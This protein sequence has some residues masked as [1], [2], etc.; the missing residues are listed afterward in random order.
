MF[1]KINHFFL[2]GVILASTLASTLFFTND[3]NAAPPGVYV[4]PKVKADATASALRTTLALCFTWKDVNHLKGNGDTIS[5]SDIAKGE[6]FN[7]SNSSLKARTGFI[8]DSDDGTVQCR[9]LFEDRNVAGAFGYGTNIELACGIGLTRENGSNCVNGTGDFKDSIG[10][11]ESKIYA[12]L[13]KKRTNATGGHGYNQIQDY[14]LAAE[15]YRIA[16]KAKAVVEV[17]KATADQK[18]NDDYHQV[19]VVNSKGEIVEVLYKRDNNDK[20]AWKNSTAGGNFD[21]SEQKC[22]GLQAVMNS[23]AKEYSAYVQNHQEDVKDRTSDQG[24]KDEDEEGAGTSCKVEAVG[25]VICP[26]MRF[27]SQVTDQAYNILSFFLTVPALSTD[28]SQGLYQAWSVMRNF[29]NVAF[30]IAFMVIIYSQITGTG[31]NNYGIKKMLPKL[32]IAAILVNISYWICAIAVDASNIVGSSLKGL[33]DSIAG[34]LYTAEESAVQSG[35]GGRWDLLTVGL[36]GGTAAGIAIYVGLSALLPMLIMALFAVVTVVLI[37][38]LRQALIVILVFLSPLAFVAFLLP[39]T[40]SLFNKWKNLFQLLL[41]M[42]PII[43][44]LFGACKLASTVIMESNP[45]FILQVLAAGVTVIP[46]FIT[47]FII[48]STSGFLNRWTG[49]VNNPNKGPFDRMRKRAEAYRDYRNDV[50]RGNRLGRASKLMSAS[51]GKLGDSYSKRRRALGYLASAGETSAVNKAKKRDFAKAVSSDSS[52][53]YL[54]KRALDQ[55]GFAQQIAGSASSAA[56]FMASAQSAVDKI[57]KQDIANRE[58]LLTA[59]VRFKNNPQV[60]LDQALKDGDKVQAAAAISMLMKTGAS[61]YGKIFDSIKKAE[62]DG[63]GE[64]ATMETVRDFVKENGK[65][66]KEKDPAMIR[67]AT[68]SA[69]DSQT[70]QPAV[71]SSLS[72]MASNASVFNKSDAE[73]AAFAPDAFKRAAD[74]GAI[75]QEQARNILGNA[76][77]LKDTSPENRAILEQIKNGTHPAAPAT[78]GGTP[79]P[80]PAPA[81]SPTPPAGGGGNAPTPQRVTAPYSRDDL[82]RLGP[83]NIQM[84]INSAGG[85][86]NLSD[87]DVAKIMNA[88]RTHP[89]AGNADVQG[90]HDAMRAERDSRRGGGT[91]PATPPSTPPTPPPTS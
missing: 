32:I 47:P 62:D 14:V 15:T 38:T 4:D 89:N 36:L 45:S 8:V 10:S 61:G 1:K 24:E 3:A 63:R 25:W 85:T 35:A 60:A 75:S 87:G 30:V 91:P 33:M 81:P 74:A 2:L 73:V 67:W 71:R 70:G 77:I 51:G 90:L 41:V 29:A 66:F 11:D 17:S 68:Q 72:Q 69:V 27:M 48:K 34:Q 23:T 18:N 52:Q 56:G 65:A 55:E 57:L 54:A 20:H 42:F 49:F 5:A 59:D 12:G 21:Y 37:L 80:T 40:E 53:E 31:L 83:Q 19:K 46:L 39:N 78:N 82:Q 79:S 84:M 43:A 76:N 86:G 44:L 16:C 28:T 6:W 88:M 13:D 50:N 26:A 22:D 64:T 7:P 9:N 58:V